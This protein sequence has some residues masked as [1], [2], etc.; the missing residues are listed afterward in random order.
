[1][2]SSPSSPPSGTNGATTDTARAVAGRGNTPLQVTADGAERRPT[3]YSILVRGD[4]ESSSILS[5][6]S[7]ESAVTLFDDDVRLLSGSV[8]GETAG[9]VVEG[10]IIAAEFD[11]PEPTVKL[12]DAV[13]DTDRWPT[14]E[15][16]TGHGPNQDPVE[17][18]FP[19][20]GE[21]GAPSGDPLAPD[22]YVV[23]LDASDAEGP[24]AY[25]FDVDGAVFDGEDATT[26]SAN[27][28]RAYGC[29]APD[30]TTRIELRGVVT[31]IDTEDGLSFSIREA[32]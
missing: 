18:P 6:A 24:A 9:F 1:M 31:R 15:E 14:V 8:A 30:E 32:N 13:V 11:D 12:G 17:D 28:D 25:C 20:S 27:G 7:P 10:T 26:V 22:E 16:Y 3:G 19:N 2:D 5:S 4:V 21:L 29:L 23:E